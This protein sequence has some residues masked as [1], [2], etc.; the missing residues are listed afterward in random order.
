MN[1]L[2]P[3]GG[4]N[5]A[6]AGSGPMHACEPLPKSLSPAAYSARP[7]IQPAC[8]GDHPTHR[9]VFLLVLPPPHPPTHPSTP[10]HLH[11][12]WAPSSSTAATFTMPAAWRPTWP[13]RRSTRAARPAAPASATPS[14]SRTARCV[15]AVSNVLLKLT[16]PTGSSDGPAP[17]AWVL[18]GPGCHPGLA[19]GGVA[20]GM[21]APGCCQGD[22]G[23]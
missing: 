13:S 14:L 20:P 23:T 18:L 3:C 15:L 7:T 6:P 8:H 1:S 9:L 4:Q 22:C 19:A 17:G 12:A 21:N 10:P 2:F 5:P 11:Q 16:S